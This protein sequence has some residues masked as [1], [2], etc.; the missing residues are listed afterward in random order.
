MGQEILRTRPDQRR[1]GDMRIAVE[2]RLMIEVGDLDQRP[3]SNICV[4][5]GQITDLAIALR[6]P[7]GISAP[8]SL[9]PHAWLLLA[10]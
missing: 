6:P 5:S 8:P 3:K 9:K 10:A 7:A 4:L 1:L 2:N